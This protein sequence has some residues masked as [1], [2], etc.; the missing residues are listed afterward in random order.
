M[1]DRQQSDMIRKRVREEYGK[2]ARHEES[3]CCQSSTCCGGSSCC[4]GSA[5]QEAPQKGERLGYTAEELESAPQGANMSLGCGNPS[6][7]G[8]L[9]P[10][11]TVLDLGSGG[12]LDCFLA[13]RQVGDSGRVVGVDMT[14]EMVARARANAAQGGY[15]NV[16]FRLGEIEHIPAA[17]GSMDVI[18]SNC[19]IN[20]SP[21]KQA[22]FDEAYR[23]LKRGGRLAISDMVATAP[24][25]VAMADDMSLWADCLAGAAL[26]DDLEDMLQKA[27]FRDLC[28]QPKE[29]SRELVREWVPGRG[30]EDYILSAT[31]EARKPA[32]GDGQD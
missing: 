26:V 7:I 10:G 17:D 14:P 32:Q 24:L 31:I 27:G 9:K 13:A 21:D 3:S 6:A 18:I 23:V 11:E 20:L 1:I 19:V 16:E 22:V 15:T 8:A 28:I 29:E 5:P 2:V 12:G 30:L 4:G 25:P